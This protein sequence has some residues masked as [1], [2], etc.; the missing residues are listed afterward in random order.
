MTDLTTHD[1][2]DATPSHGVTHELTAGS[3]VGRYTIER[4]AGAGAM[5]V[6]YA[7]RD[8]RLDRTV[9][10]KILNGGRGS[11]VVTRLD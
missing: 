9:A 1:G 11:D 3:R 2:V 6:V 5:G 10:L 8:S 7:A 4:R